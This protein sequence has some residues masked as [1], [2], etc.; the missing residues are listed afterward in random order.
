MYDKLGR[1][2]RIETTVNDLAFFKHHRKVEHKNGPSSYELAPLKK[3]IYSLVDLRDILTSCNR[4]YLEYL[5]ALDDHSAG[6][7]A[8]DRLSGERRDGER[9]VKGL[10]FF[11]PGEQAL[12]RALKRPEFNIRGMRRADLKALLPQF[13][14]AALSR[15]IKR[16]R[17]LGLLKRVAGTYHYYLTRLGRGAIAA[18]CSI[19]EFRIVP[20]L[21]RAK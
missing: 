19:T 20:A 1:I 10:N 9:P 4:R 6:S 15:Q 2:L 12:L 16:L 18:A 14:P 21:A 13:N 7:R 11:A 3:T 17:L 5:S 8:L